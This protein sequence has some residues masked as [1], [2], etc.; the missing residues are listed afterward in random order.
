MRTDYKG[1]CL[2]GEFGFYTEQFRGLG[3]VCLTRRGSVGAVLLEEKAVGMQYG[4]G[5]QRGPSGGRG[6]P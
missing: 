5:R 4:R 3:V 1:P 2:S 6:V